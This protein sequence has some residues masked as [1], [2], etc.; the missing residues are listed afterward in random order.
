MLQKERLTVAFVMRV[1]RLSRNTVENLR[2]GKTENPSRRTLSGAARAVATDPQSLIMDDHK[3]RKAERALHV[4]AGFAAPTTD[5]IETMLELLLY[6]RVGSEERARAW[7]ATIE[8]LAV[9]DAPAVLALRSG[10]ET[11]G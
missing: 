1:G 10:S 4:A 5:D 9:L 2:D 8:R 7:A 11:H 3:M 6:Y